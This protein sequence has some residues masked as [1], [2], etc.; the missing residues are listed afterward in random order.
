MKSRAAV[1]G[2]RLCLNT[3]VFLRCCVGNF[4]L[5]LYADASHGSLALVLCTG[6]DTAVSNLRQQPLSAH[7]VGAE[8]LEAD[9][10]AI[11]PCEQTGAG[12]ARAPRREWLHAN[13]SAL[14][15]SAS[16]HAT[17][18]ALK[19]V[20]ARN[21][22]SLE[23][24]RVPEGLLV[25]ACAPNFDVW[26]REG[27]L[28]CDEN[29]LVEIDT[30]KTLR[31]CPQAAPYTLI[32]CLQPLQPDASV[33]SLH[34]RPAEESMHFGH[35]PATLAC[36]VELPAVATLLCNRSRDDFVIQVPKAAPAE[37]A[38]TSLVWYDFAEGY[39][40]HAPPANAT[41]SLS[42]AAGPNRVVPC[43]SVAHATVWRNSDD[44][45]KC[46]FACI[47]PFVQTGSA[48]VSPCAGLASACAHAAV[49]SC[50]DSAGSQFYDCMACPALAGFETKAF[51]VG[52]PAYACAYEGCAAGTASSE[53]EHTCNACPRN[54]IADA[55]LAHR[56]VSCNTSTSGLFSRAVGGVG[57]S[58]CFAEP[59]RSDLCGA[60]G[61]QPGRGMEDDFW[62]V[63]ALFV[64]YSEDRPAVLLEDYVEEYC[65]QGYACLPCPPG[66][67]EDRGLCT[68][69]DYGTYQHNFGA[70][71]C[72]GCDAGQNTTAR[73]Q[74]SSTACVCT[75]GFE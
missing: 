63:S 8:W 4:A 57:C 43:P 12:G 58:A 61:G 26:R 6:L 28:E 33:V 7:A 54:S 62:R 20:F 75:P 74:N 65:M 1:G 14:A 41:F 39:G 68:P 17:E 13:A 18:M 3:L 60:T 10:V 5:P 11:N 24:A 44:P 45:T 72:F 46:D 49:S 31:G 29:T 67:F 34:W 15:T 55:P 50:V 22:G 27:A 36:A 37:R 16:T 66:T 70:T 73:G 2:A 19:G 59:G 42:R 40:C 56:C 53:D 9:C 69:C 71:A 47:A 32:E 64:L 30:V 23:Y 35:L 21:F 48:C 25:R 51:E 38:Q 52:A